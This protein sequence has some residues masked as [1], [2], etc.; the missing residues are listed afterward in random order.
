MR[1]LEVIRIRWIT[2]LEV[3]TPSPQYDGLI[4]ESLTV[5]A[6]I[7]TLVRIAETDN[8]AQYWHNLSSQQSAI[9]IGPVSTV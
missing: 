9:F 8:T 5:R 4:E 1:V 3:I 7:Y 2:I 6:A